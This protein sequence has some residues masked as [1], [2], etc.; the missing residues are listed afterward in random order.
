MQATL[1]LKRGDTSMNEMLTALGEHPLV[2]AGEGDRNWLPLDGKV[3]PVSS[4]QDHES[5]YNVKLTTVLGFNLTVGYSR[6]KDPAFLGCTHA[7]V[8]FGER[9]SEKWH[10]ELTCC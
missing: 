6:H 7:W 2:V 8:V 3:N 1:A 10:R 9:C 5:V 4:K